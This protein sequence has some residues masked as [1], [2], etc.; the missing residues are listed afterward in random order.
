MADEYDLPK[1]EL[2]KGKKGLIMGVANHNSIAW[3]IAAQMAAQGAE[4]AFSY[5]GE[6]LERR[7]RP[8]AESVGSKLLIQADV[9]DD[10]SMDAA[11]AEVE[12]AFGTLDF[13]V[14]SIAFADKEQ[15]RGSFVENTT[16]EGFLSAMN[17]SAYSFVDCSR[18]AAKL[19]PNGGSIICMTYLGAERVIP[20]Y[21]V[22]GVAKAALEASTRYVARDLGPQGIRVNAISAGAMR[23]LSLAGISG[24]RGMLS[25]GRAFSALKED[26]SMEGVAGAALWLLSDL[27]RSTTGEV[28]H[29]DAGFHMVGLP[30]GF[31]A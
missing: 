7:V 11:F 29:V 24:G 4:L 12:K 18:R 14:H 21:N 30:D 15:L 5:L 27:G 23:T 8:L 17:I 16:R 6:G 9:A 31:E 26:T 22:M 25:Q 13:L 1:G 19:M 3:G 2:M 10:A 20:N 28:V